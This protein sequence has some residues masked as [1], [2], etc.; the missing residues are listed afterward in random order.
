MIFCEGPQEKLS[1]MPVPIE[2]A[3]SCRMMRDQIPCQLLLGESHPEGA[4]E[5]PQD[6]EPAAGAQGG[7]E[8]RHAARSLWTGP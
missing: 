5:E 6:N 8:D 2:L 4:A 7:L 3:E 1:E